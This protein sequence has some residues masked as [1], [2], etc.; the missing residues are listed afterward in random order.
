MMDTRRKRGRPPKYPKA[1]I[2][3][4]PKIEMSE[5]EIQEELA[6]R[7]LDDPIAYGY[8]RFLPG[9]QCPDERC[10]LRAREHYHCVRERCHHATDSSEVLALHCKDFHSY[11]NILPGFE[12][13]DLEV[14]CRRPHCHNNKVHRHYHCV[15]PR[16]DYS[17]VRYGTMKTHDKKHRLAEAGLTPSPTIAVPTAAIMSTA[18]HAALPCI[19]PVDPGLMPI[20]TATTASLPKIKPAD[21]QKLAVLPPPPSSA[22]VVIKSES[23]ASPPASQPLASLLQAPGSQHPAVA[24]PTL[25]SRMKHV[26]DEQ[27]S[28]PFCKLKKKDHYHCF[29]CDQAFS[30]PFKVKSHVLKHGVKID[31]D[32]ACFKAVMT[33]VEAE[34][35]R[36]SQ[37]QQEASANSDTD[38]N[39]EEVAAA[40]GSADPSMSLTLEP[41][42]FASMVNQ[43][44]ISST[45]A[46]ADVPEA[47]IE[48]QSPSAATP[49]V[50][51]LRLSAAAITHPSMPRSGTNDVRRSNRKRQPS[52]SGDYIMEMPTKRQKAE[53][54][55]CNKTPQGGPSPK[56][57][58]R[59]L[60]N[61]P[62]PDGFERVPY[63]EHC[64]RTTCTYSGNQTHYHCQRDNCSF[65]TPDRSRLENHADRHRKTDDAMGDEFV[66]YRTKQECGREGCE[67]HNKGT[68]YHCLR[69]T[70]VCSDMSKVVMHRKQHA[71]QQLS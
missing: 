53:K 19:L 7:G 44:Q 54:A 12:F 45:T 35:S 14:N 59:A 4:V 51:P 60:K 17:F 21:V 41:G 8:R 57:R 38:T 15:R 26:A 34:A 46:L 43:S 5:R 23:G 48:Q 47:P 28:R 20:S 49:K 1:N 9:Q 62:V 11:I 67:F 18:S 58:M 70:F 50:P 66:R 33:K 31:A 39:E 24:W 52:D 64:L 56:R 13:F 6:R 27:C 32:E 61:V 65:S 37:G 30:D 36:R 2:P 68:H 71:R 22:G 63:T 10:A 40:N 42:L 29:E 25:L 55:D 16:C 3:N 69:C